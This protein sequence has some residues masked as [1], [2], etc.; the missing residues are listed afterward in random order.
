MSA[1]QALMH[2]CRARDLMVALAASASEAAAAAADAEA[3]LSAALAERDELQQAADALRRERTAL[4]AANT[5]Q[6]LKLRKLEEDYVALQG[7][8]DEVE[9]MFGKVEAMKQ[10]YERRLGRYKAR[11]SELTD[12]L[13][14]EREAAQA[15]IT[16]ITQV[17]P[18]RPKPLADR[19]D[20]GLVAADSSDGDWYQP[21]EL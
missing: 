11:V 19:S 9:T 18:A 13:R 4:Q 14:R 3:R 15:D 1:L 16:P 20:K 5:E 6:G 21:L 2:P 12:A 7:E 17:A 8:I 10:A